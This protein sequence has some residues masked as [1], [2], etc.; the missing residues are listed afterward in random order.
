MGIVNVTPDS[1]SDG[2]DHLAAAD[3]IAAGL[4]MVGAGAAVIDIGG[5]STRPVAARP[6]D[7]AEEQA[8]VLPVLRGLAGC[9][10]LLSVD[11]RNAAT[12]QAALRA[13]ADIV[14]D[15]SALAHD[16]AA[17]G[18]VAAAACPV[19]LMHMRGTPQTM[20]A[21]ADYAD[22]M[23]EV[24]RELAARVVAAEAAGIARDRIAVDPGIGFAKRLEHN[25]AILARL[26]LLANLGCRVLLGVSR[27]RFI[28]RL[29]GVVPGRLGPKAT[30]AGSLAAALFGLAHGAMVLRVHD[31]PDTVQAVRVWQ[32]LAAR[33][34]AAGASTGE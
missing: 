34:P 7:A 26:P 28:M 32:G 15:V 19:V 5:E 33:P 1:F 10:A 4:A 2:G 25:A 21:H 20:H 3:A 6:V 18:V 30:T 14:N 17:A 11:T 29:G 23:P 27:K 16:P 31:V 22:T 24:V 12:M 8:R 13:G 9:G